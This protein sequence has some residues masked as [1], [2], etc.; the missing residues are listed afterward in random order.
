[1]QTI[2]IR[3]TDGSTSE[4]KVTPTAQVAFERQYK[5]GIA[6]LGDA[7]TLRMEYMYWLAW[8]DT[9]VGRPNRP[10]FDDWLATVEELVSDVEEPE[11][12]PL[13]VTPP[14]GGSLPLPSNP[15]PA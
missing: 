9:T 13:V 7:S 5:V 10:S 3:H 2:T 15:A 11:P 12:S 14:S 1:M 6:A 4:A 8:F